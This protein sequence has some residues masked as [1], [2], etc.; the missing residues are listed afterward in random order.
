[1][2][3]TLGYKVREN[4]G[5][6]ALLWLLP[7]LAYAPS[8][9]QD[10]LPFAPGGI[11][12]LP[13][14]QEGAP[15]TY[16]GVASA[17]LST[18]QLTTAWP[19][20]QFINAHRHD[21]GA[22][23]WNPDVALG[24]PFLANVQNR[25]LSFFT[26]PFYLFDLQIAWALSLWLKMVVAGCAAY[27]GARRY[28]FTAGFAL[29]VALVFQWS[30]PVFLWGAEPMGD[31]LPWFPLLLLAT[32][33]LLLG[34]FKAW[35]KLAAV[36]ALMAVGG[37]LR[38]LAILLGMMLAYMLL[39]RLRDGHHVYLTAALPGYALGLAVG[40][41][42]AAPQL[43]PYAILLREGSTAN[44]VY[45]WPL[46]VETILGIFGPA[47]M[48]AAGGPA[49]PLVQLVNVGLIPLLL[50][51]VWLSLR[52]FVE[53]PIRHRVE[54]LG[55]A[56][57]AVAAIPFI[58]GDRMGHLPLLRLVHPAHCLVGL[59]LP[60][61]LMV[62][63]ASEAWLHLDADECKQVL[64]RMALILPVYWGGL[65]AVWVVIAVRG[66]G[67]GQPWVGLAVFV[68]VLALLVVLFAVTLLYPR[69]RV[70]AAG[71]VT[72]L[73]VLMAWGQFPQV[74]QSDRALIFPE[75]HLIKALRAVGARVG[76]AES[77]R[78]WPLCGNQ[79]PALYARSTA[80]LNRTTQFLAQVDR[81]PLLQ[82]RAGVGS[83]LLQRADVQ[84]AYAPVR[85]D[86]N[87]LD[88]FESGAVLFRDLSTAASYRIAHAVQPAAEFDL[89]HLT[90][91]SPPCVEGFDMPGRE[92]PF[93]DK[94]R[95]TDVPTH[96][97][98][99]LEIESNQPGIVIF[100][101]AWYPGWRAS[102]DGKE[103][104]VYVVDGAFQGVE[105]VAGPHEL[106]LSYE[107]GDFRYGLIIFVGSLIILLVGV[108]L[109]LRR[110]RCHI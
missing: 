12:A 97:R 15:A 88:V 107:P 32:D 3:R 47:G 98:I 86:L 64:R 33:R 61:A 53:K 99:P 57:L 81:D 22:L 78:A 90:L 73:L 96:T 70:M 83:L 1:M 100:T 51:G 8:L 11:L 55:F 19:A 14:W 62:A 68:G 6:V 66:H 91:D 87:I 4:A 103:T 37:E 65:I 26:L 5:C 109:S 21:L 44:G 80:A 13:P 46:P 17:P 24:Q 40:L 48:P 35:P 72:S 34:Q 60:L 101:T 93:E 95:L 7:A 104:E 52:R 49:N 63:G 89:D 85:A 69:P 67:A 36:V 45:P 29:I 71:I 31:I 102:V 23:L 74:V 75:T 28:G 50:A 43:L 9:F 18:W 58:T 10:K 20:Y 76:G 59:A 42:L 39:R 110:S 108:F 79:I 106:I 105:L 82:R 30:G 54:C 38:I 41:G 92:G 16:A 84:G 94:I 27:Y 56:A 2:I 77:L 25:C